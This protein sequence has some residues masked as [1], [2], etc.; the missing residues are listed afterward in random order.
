MSYI[1]LDTVDSTNEYVKKN[2]DRLNN[3][4]VVRCNY[5]TSGKGRNGHVWQSKPGED[6]LMSILVKD[7]KNPQDL[8]KMTQIAAC[9]V[10]GL[11]ERYGIKAKIKWPNDVYVDDLKICGILVEAVFESNLKGIIVGIGLNVN[12]ISGS[13]ASM[14]MK[15]GQEYH[16]KSLM[17]AMLTYF[18]IYYN[19]YC[20][21]CYDKILDYANDIA[22]L[23]DKKVN[24]EDYGLVTFTSLNEDGTVDFID[25]N[26]IK[27]NKLINEISLHSK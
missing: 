2:I 6:L 20:Q 23:K 18:N 14:K 4:S 24:F 12:S 10:V 22:Y 9:S 3:L 19:L 17:I 13:F 26:N 8:H 11:L 27:H 21:G 7:F 1:E 16:V 25:S 15:T 5:Q